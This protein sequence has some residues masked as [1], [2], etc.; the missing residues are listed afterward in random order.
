MNETNAVFQEIKTFI[1]FT[2]VDVAALQAIAPIFAAH[3]A[4]ITDLFYVKLERDPEQS[5]LIEGR[6]EALKRTHNRW[7]AELFAGEY[8]EAYFNDRWR[9]GLAHVRVGVK[10]WWVEAV[11]S[12]LRTEGLGLLTNEISDPAQRT[13]SVQALVK[14][15]DIDLMIINLAYSQE[16]IDRLSQFTGMSRKLI[17]RCVQLKK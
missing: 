2:D 8:G 14:I 6:V 16:T 13:R 4:A 15:L 1:G 12:F 3:G 9:I 17:E 11:T 10:P 7:M 5:K